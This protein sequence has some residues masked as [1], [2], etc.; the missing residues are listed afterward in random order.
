MSSLNMKFND[1]QPK[2]GHYRAE[3]I[4]TIRHGDF[5]TKHLRDKVVGSCFKSASWYGSGM[6][7]F[8]KAPYL[9]ICTLSQGINSVFS[10][11]LLVVPS[12]NLGP[13]TFK[14][15]YLRGF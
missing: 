4:N 11:F 8:L 5:H 2:Q 12:S 15:C 7:V 13:G 1:E 10:L 6:E 9:D 3:L 14:P